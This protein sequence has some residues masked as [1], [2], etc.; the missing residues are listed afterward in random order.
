MAQLPRKTKGEFFDIILIL[1]SALEAL[2][3]NVNFSPLSVSDDGLDSEG[4]TR[5]A[6]PSTQEDA[7]PTPEDKM[8]GPNSI[9][10]DLSDYVPMSPRLKDLAL[11]ELQR[12][13]QQEN[14]YM[15][16]R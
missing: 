16:M 5:S 11:Q 7:T 9:P 4:G 14:M 12:Q 10:V 8:T 1:F 3:L 15:V 2:E 13:T 6:S